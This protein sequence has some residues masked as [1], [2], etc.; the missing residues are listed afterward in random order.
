MFPPCSGSTVSSCRQGRVACNTAATVVFAGLRGW[1]PRR[2]STPQWRPGTRGY[3]PPQRQ[4]CCARTTHLRFLGLAGCPPREGQL[5]L[6]RCA[7]AAHVGHGP[8]V[9]NRPSAVAMNAETLL[10]PC[11][12]GP[13]KDREWV[14]EP[15]LEPPSSARTPAGTPAGTPSNAPTPPF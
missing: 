6:W 13:P 5:E 15:P 2:T 8:S 12:W 1:S 9:R 14:L 10:Q 3:P 7:H 11:P 4:P